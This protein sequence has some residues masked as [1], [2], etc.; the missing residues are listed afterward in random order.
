MSLHAARQIVIA[1]SDNLA[2]CMRWTTCLTGSTN[3]SPTL[4]ITPLS[5]VAVLFVIGPLSA[6]V[7]TLPQ[8]VRVA[9]KR[10]V[11]DP[12]VPGCSQWRVS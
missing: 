12:R 9:A 8:L 2:A 1:L 10:G 7:S 3:H 4:R 11:A 6:V 5:V